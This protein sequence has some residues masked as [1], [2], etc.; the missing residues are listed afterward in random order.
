MIPEIEIS[1]LNKHGERFEMVV[2]KE[3]T[4]YKYRKLYIIMKKLINPRN[5]NNK[6]EEDK[7][8]YRLLHTISKTIQKDT[9]EHK[10]FKSKVNLIEYVKEDSLKKENLFKRG[11]FKKGNSFL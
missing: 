6:K 2:N 8:L 10:I 3:L 5:I 4:P 7:T 1:Y 11:I 9:F